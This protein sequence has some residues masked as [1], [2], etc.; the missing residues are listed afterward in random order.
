MDSGSSLVLFLLADQILVENK[1]RVIS[2][3]LL[4]SEGGACTVFLLVM[5]IIEVWA[6]QFASYQLRCCWPWMTCSFWPLR[7]TYRDSELC[8]L[9]CCNASFFRHEFCTY[10]GCERTD[11][12]SIIGY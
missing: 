6:L 3:W 10:H 12:Q 11:V 4:R 8:Q 2:D 1:T 5:L 7:F 9:V